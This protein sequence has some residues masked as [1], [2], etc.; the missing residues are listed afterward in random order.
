MN[1]GD[2]RERGEPEQQRDGECQHRTNPFET[3]ERSGE[4]RRSFPV[5]CGVPYLFFPVKPDVPWAGAAARGIDAGFS[6]WLPLRAAPAGLSQGFLAGRQIHMEGTCNRCP[7]RDL[8]WLVPR[9]PE[10]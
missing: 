6:G 4:S 2:G 8:R 10:V 1:D 3:L 7:P 9:F 5:E